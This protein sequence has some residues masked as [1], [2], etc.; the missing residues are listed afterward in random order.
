MRVEEGRVCRRLDSRGMKVQ[1]LVLLMF[2]GEGVDGN[3]DQLDWEVV[4]REF[5]MDMPWGCIRLTEAWLHPVGRQ[6]WV[7]RRSILPLG[8]VHIVRMGLVQVI[9]MAEAL[10]ALLDD[11]VVMAILYRCLIP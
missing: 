3:I 8:W 9:G 7:L 4:R 1:G 10:R 5:G 11:S 2:R 6:I